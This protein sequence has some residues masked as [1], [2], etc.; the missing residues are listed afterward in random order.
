MCSDASETAPSRVS[1]VVLSGCLGSPVAINSPHTGSRCNATLERLTRRSLP[2]HGGRLPA[3]A[4]ADP[5]A[6][7]GLQT[8]LHRV[9]YM[10]D[11]FGYAEY[12][13][14]VVKFRVALMRAPI[15]RSRPRAGPVSRERRG[16]SL[17][18]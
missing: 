15:G 13:S 8:R 5:D 2:G 16:T 12:L 9:P 17:R 11:C 18:Y 7:G 4:N 6:L 3:S 1:V 14:D 10:P